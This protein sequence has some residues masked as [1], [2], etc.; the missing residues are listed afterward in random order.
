MGSSFPRE[1]GQR[2]ELIQEIYNLATDEELDMLVR[3]VRDT[4]KIKHE[5]SKKET[6]VL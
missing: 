2:I 6:A 3:I 5:H 4:K 1:E